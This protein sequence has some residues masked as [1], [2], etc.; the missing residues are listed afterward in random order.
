MYLCVYTFM[1]SIKDAD[2]YYADSWSF[3]CSLLRLVKIHIV[4]NS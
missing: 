4:L 2:V 1:N 3:C